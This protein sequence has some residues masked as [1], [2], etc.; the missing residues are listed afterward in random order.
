VEKV[1]V[2]SI[3]LSAIDGAD[4][5]GLNGDL[6]LHRLFVDLEE[7]YRLQAIFGSEGQPLMIHSDQ[8][9]VTSGKGPLLMGTETTISLCEILSTK[10]TMAMTAKG[11]LGQPIL[12]TATKAPKANSI[13]LEH[14]LGPRDETAITLS[15][16]GLD[17]KSLLA[18][19]AGL[20]TENGAWAAFG[21]AQG[22]GKENVVLVG[23]FLAEL[24]INYELNLQLT[25]PEGETIKYFARASGDIDAKTHNSLINNSP[26]GQ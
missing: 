5:C 20:R 8:G 13:T 25:N 18:D 6:I 16:F 1:F 10:L 21:G 7:G 22:L 11:F 12:E 19:E 23:H 2:E 14:L 24:P 26:T 17:T 9:F 4:D 15:S 3:P